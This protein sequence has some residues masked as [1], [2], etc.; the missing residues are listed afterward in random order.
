MQSSWRVEAKGGRWL[1][2]YKLGAMRGEARAEI[3]RIPYDIPPQEKKK[4]SHPASKLVAVAMG[5]FA[6]SVR[7]W[8]RMDMVKVRL[9]RRASK[10]I[11]KE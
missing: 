1:A 9:T 10:G 4:R 8:G 6:R 2:R 7:P 3:G 11:D 5:Q